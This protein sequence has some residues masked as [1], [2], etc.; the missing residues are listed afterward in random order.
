M[1]TFV[2]PLFINAFSEVIAT[3]VMHNVTGLLSD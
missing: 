3:A 2:P 1:A